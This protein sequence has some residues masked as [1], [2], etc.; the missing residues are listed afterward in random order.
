MHLIL[1][2]LLTQFSQFRVSYKCELQLSKRDLISKWAHFNCVKEEERLKQYKTESDHM[3]S[4]FK[5]K[6]IEKKKNKD[7][8]AA[9]KYTKYNK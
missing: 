3:S 5:Y 6:D 8:E 1:I 9:V 2:F 7:K 4:T